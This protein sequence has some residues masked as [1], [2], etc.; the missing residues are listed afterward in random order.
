M[1]RREEESENEIKNKILI[2]SYASL[3]IEDINSYTEERITASKK[4]H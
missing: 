1:I 3:M 4:K 2:I